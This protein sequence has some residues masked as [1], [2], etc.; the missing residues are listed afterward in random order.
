[1][2]ERKLAG[3]HRQYNGGGV[4]PVPEV[5]RVCPLSS[6]GYKL[7]LWVCSRVNVREE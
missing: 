6:V 4:A 3:C 7:N 2:I 5:P 1:L